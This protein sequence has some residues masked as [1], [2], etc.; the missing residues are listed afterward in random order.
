MPATAPEAMRVDKWLWHARFFKSR[1]LA[2]EVVS[3]GRLRVNGAHARKPAT[4][5]RPGD[6]L[7]FAQ[8]GAIRVIR[9]TALSVR[10][11]PAAEARGLYEDL[12]PPK[13]PEPGSPVSAPGRP[14][15]KAR[16]AARESKGWRVE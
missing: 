11:G 8:G 9:I 2:A 3:G 5:V 12:D 15:R 10:R 16:R 14:D 13:P 1:S 7:T 6:T 4:P